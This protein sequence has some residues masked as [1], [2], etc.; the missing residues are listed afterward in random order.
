MEYLLHSQTIEKFY[1]VLYL[2]RA[3]SL[4]KRS[5]DLIWRGSWTGDFGVGVDLGVERYRKEEVVFLTATA[6]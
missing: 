6:G 5:S 3:T 2:V 4:T 1:V